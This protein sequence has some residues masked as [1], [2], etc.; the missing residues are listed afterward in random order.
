[1]ASAGVNIH[2]A[3]EP[4]FS[5]LPSPPPLAVSSDSPSSVSLKKR[6]HFKRTLFTETQR[7]ILM[8]WL[9]MHQKNP[10]PTTS[11]KEYLMMETGLQRDQINVWFTNNRIRQGITSAHRF[12]D[13]RGDSS[14]M[15]NFR[16]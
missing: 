1:M 7:Q 8:G 11:E 14:I 9:K 5:V 2:R 13:E 16:R 4:S 10:Y 15:A 12:G 3:E 6:R